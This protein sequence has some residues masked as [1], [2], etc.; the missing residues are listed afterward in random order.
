MLTQL[1]TGLNHHSECIAPKPDD[2]WSR[3]QKEDMK[4]AVDLLWKFKEALDRLHPECTNLM[5][6][7]LQVPHYRY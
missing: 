3:N 2:R 5:E 4:E 7:M 1:N 6:R